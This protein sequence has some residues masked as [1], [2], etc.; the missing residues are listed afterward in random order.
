[1]PRRRTSP[2]NDPPKKIA[3]PRPG[4]RERDQPTESNPIARKENF[5]TI[6]LRNFHDRMRGGP[7]PVRSFQIY[8]GREA[9]YTVWGNFSTSVQDR[10]GEVWRAPILPMKPII[11]LFV[12]IIGGKAVALL[13]S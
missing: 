8:L 1:M 12:H 3:K 2:K 6:E 9:A 11:D 7:R 5:W 10:R 4:Q 13:N